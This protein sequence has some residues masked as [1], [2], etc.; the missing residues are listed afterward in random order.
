MV[1]TTAEQIPVCSCA[2]CQQAP[3]GSIAQLH[4]GINR[5]AAALD[6][7]HRR[8]FVGVWAAQLGHGGVQHMARVTGLSRTTILRGRREIEQIERGSEGR[9]R[10]AG[11]GRKRVEKKGLSS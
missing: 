8:W 7:K 10:R 5:V 3:R 4:A 11:G 2:T 1:E 9:I 6:E